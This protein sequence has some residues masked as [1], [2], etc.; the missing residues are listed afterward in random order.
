MKRSSKPTGGLAVT[1]L[2]ARELAAKDENGYSDPY[3][4]LRV[5]TQE[6]RTK[7]V[8]ISLNP[9]WDE[10]FE[11]THVPPGALLR[12][13]LY[14]EDRMKEDDFLGEALVPLDSAA[15]P[16][17][18][19]EW[20]R[21]EVRPG[22]SE[23][24]CGEVCLRVVQGTGA[25]SS[26]KKARTASPAPPMALASQYVIDASELTV[27]GAKLGEGGFG[28][29]RRGTFRGLGVAVKTLLMRD[30]VNKKELIGE[31]KE[32][33]AMLAKVSHHPK[34]C[35]FLG[36]SVKEPLTLVN[37]LMSGSVRSLLDQGYGEPHAVQL[38]R[39]PWRRRVE[40]LLDAA[41]GMA[42]LHNCDPPVVHRDLKADNLLV[43]AHGN[44]KVADFG[45]SRTIE[46]NTL[47]GDYGTPG[48]K[49]PEMY[50][51]SK[52]AK[53]YSLPVDVF[54]FGMIAYELL[55]G[56]AWPY[57]WALD[58]ATDE[59]VEDA[60]SKGLPP[61]ALGGSPLPPDAPPKLLSLH[62]ACIATKPDSRPAFVTRRGAQ[63]HPSTIVPR[64]RA[65]LLESG[66]ARSCSRRGQAEAAPP[67]PKADLAQLLHRP[68]EQQRGK[69]EAA[70]SKPKAAKAP[71]VGKKQLQKK[72]PSKTAEPAVGQ[73]AARERKPPET[74]EAEPAPPPAVPAAQQRGKIEAAPS[75]PKAAKAPDVG[76][77]QL[78]NKK[79]PSKMAE[80]AV[81]QRAARERKPPETFKAE[82]APP[83][84][85]LAAQARRKGS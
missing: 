7:T 54:A 49:A 16:S 83:P 82:P 70:P 46:G 21:L 13:A 61:S 37:E 32:E 48:F 60:V 45:L 26:S 8:P 53:G 4:L 31:F 85:V 11:F 81:V 55:S 66:V 68:V 23:F 29:V 57:G 84:A 20:H 18:E 25:A 59:Q 9:V 33:V 30:G 24:V 76:E 10:T 52:A 78:Q 74:F 69:T 41:L 75:K 79:Q 73:R 43:D 2:R 17:P 44:A 19:P 27:D 5:G 58:L 56:G 67:K 3:A 63:T 28:V 34:L 50:N 42:F 40:I 15:T 36:A 77:K 64:L 51:E 1:V 6:H 71:A 12:V 39:L 65:L 14:D 72:Q 80:P 38:A 35:L 47:K 22:S 62:R